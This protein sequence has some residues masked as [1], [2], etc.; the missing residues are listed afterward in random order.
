[1]KQLVT[2][3][4]IFLIRAYQYAFSPWLGTRCRFEPSCSCYAEQ[5]IAMH[6]PFKGSALALR[7]LM[8]CHPF[9]GSGYDPVPKTNR[10]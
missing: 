1:M 10:P 8:K 6:G 2:R 5:A 3:S 9:G 7:R 4:I